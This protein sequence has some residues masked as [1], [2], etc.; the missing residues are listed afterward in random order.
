ML[1]RLALAALL[2]LA[3]ACSPPG[4]RI[5]WGSGDIELVGNLILPA[6]D[7]PHP[8]VIFVSG[9]GSQSRDR[10]SNWDHSARL[11]KLGVASFVYDKRGNG[12]SGGD[13]K[14]VGLE[15]LAD[16]LLPLLD[17][18]A[19]DPR[20]DRKRVG[21]M[22]LS[23]GA[24]VALIAAQRS[25][26]VEFVIWLSG[27]PMT[28]AEQGTSIVAMGLQ[29]A[30]HGADAIA[31][32]TALDQLV[33]QVYRTDSGWEEAGKAVEAARSKP[34]FAAAGVGIQP[35]DSWNWKWVA[36]FF[37]HDPLPALRTLNKPLL[38]IWGEDD[39]IVP[40]AR[41]KAI[42][43]GLA[44]GAPAARTTVMLRGVGHELGARESAWPQEYW[45][46]IESWLRTH[47]MID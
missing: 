38:A 19:A 5:S 15:A 46:A 3:A 31:E 11:A 10:S 36:S 23:Q 1:Q 33:N 34:W 7:G 12:E 32:A 39:R 45:A 28:P 9:S 24:W 2:F 41:S 29:R 42:V 44:D 16:D 4:S 27:P 17:R 6:T 30:G 20:I 14:K 43:D 40:A 25:E 18:L 22:G 35:R 8:L 13:W 37:D 21:L 26:H 47:G